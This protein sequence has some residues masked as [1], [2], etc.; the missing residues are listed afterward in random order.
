MNIKHKHGHIRER[1]G[2]KGSAFNYLYTS[3]DT[4][5]RISKTFP[6]GTPPAV[7]Q[8]E[9]SRIEA[10]IEAFHFGLVQTFKAGGRKKGTITLGELP[11]CSSTTG[12]EIYP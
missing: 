11:T 2:K 4:G 3:P 1:K 9:V 5:E 12:A 10:E 8:Q 7:I 6:A